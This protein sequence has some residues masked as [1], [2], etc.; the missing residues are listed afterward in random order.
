MHRIQSPF[1]PNVTVKNLRSWLSL[2]GIGRPAPLP[3]TYPDDQ[4]VVVRTESDPDE[5]DLE[6]DVQI[7][8][9]VQLFCFE[10]EV[11]I[12]APLPNWLLLE[13]PP[14][15]KFCDCVYMEAN[16]KAAADPLCPYCS[17]K[18]FVYDE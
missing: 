14:E 12:W 17:G 5:D 18:G 4:F 6:D 16:D 9:G 8:S 2:P 15:P 7:L 11:V 1:L 10:P 3:E 13:K